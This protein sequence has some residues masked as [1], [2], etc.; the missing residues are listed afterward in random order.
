MLFGLVCVCA[1][2]LAQYVFFLS[3]PYTLLSR[4][5][6]VPLQRQSIG[7]SPQYGFYQKFDYQNALCTHI[8]FILFLNLSLSLALYFYRIFPFS[9]RSCFDNAR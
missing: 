5:A 8:G 9:L 4:F 2:S 7:V 6:I 1:R 3:T